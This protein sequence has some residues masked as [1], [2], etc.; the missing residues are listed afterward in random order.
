MDLD[1]SVDQ[2]AAAE[3]ARRILADHASP[4]L[5]RSME[6]D[7]ATMA[8]DAWRH[9]GAAGL[10]AVALPEEHGGA[11]L[12][13]VAA[14]ALAEEVGA[15]VAPIPYVSSVVQAGM[16]I[17]AHGTDAARTE[18]LDAVSSG[19]RILTVALAEDFTGIAPSE[20]AVRATPH[21]GGWVIDG[22]SWFV[23]WLLDADR[24]IVPATTPDG[25]IMVAL[26]PQADGVATDPVESI[27]RARRHHCTWRTVAVN[28]DEVVVGVKRGPAALRA[29]HARSQLA[30]AATL[31]G[32]CREAVRLTAAHASEREQF[33][34]KIGTFQAVAHQAANAW[35]DARAVALTTRSAA[36]RLDA[37]LP[38]D[39][40]I[41]IAAW[42]A[43]S[44]SER[45]AHTAQHLHGGIGVDTGYPL[46][47][48]FRWAKELQLTLGSTGHHLAALGARLAGD[49]V[50]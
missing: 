23:P 2:L 33:G 44:G 1:L 32:V 15:T 6:G 14:C 37:G 19:Q 29:L 26:D 13:M 8:T 20:P 30:V 7:G 47:R 45:V 4:E 10:L 42:W 5:L 43:A 49:P 12:G 17:A 24:V 18:W 25:P 48:Y 39:E 41:E 11:D 31:A 27:S 16:T 46:H 28:R 50:S 40:A 3:L 38:A 21:G 22:E 35:T 34:V 36:W 9:L